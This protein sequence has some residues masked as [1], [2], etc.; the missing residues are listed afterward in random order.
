MSFRGKVAAVGTGLAGIGEAPGLTQIDL[1]VIAAK[2]ALD[3]AGLGF[4]DVDGLFAANLQNIFA[5]L[6]VGEYLGIRP[7]LSE[8][9]QIG[10]SS[11]VAHLI[12]AALA[13]DA[14]LIDTALICY[15]S[16]Q[17]TVA[18]KLLSPS[19]SEPLI[20]EQPFGPRYPISSYALNASRHMYEYGTTREQLAS[21]AISARQWA[22]KNPDAF[23]RGPLSVDDVLGARMVA[24]PLTVRDCCLVTDGAGAVVLTRSDRARDLVKKPV[25]LLGAAMAHWHRQISQMPDLTVTCASETG[26]RAFEMAKLGPADMDVL[27]LYDAFTINT[28]MFLEDLGFFAKGEAAGFIAEG[29]IAPGGSLPVNTNGGGLSCVHPGMYGIFTVIEAIQQIRSQC[30]ERQIDGAKTA[31]SHGNGGHFSSQVT[32]IWGDGETL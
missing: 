17:R 30:G 2:Q 23:M 5:P 31:V 3:E 7:K 19:T 10:G 29:G 24:D 14:G 8:G 27:E 21:V 28:I 4:G 12:W 26:P 22:A 11:P 1:T 25:Y 32:A 15:G 13:L 16:T 6:N 20:Y 18:G 9:T